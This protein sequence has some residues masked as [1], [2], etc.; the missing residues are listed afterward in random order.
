MIVQIK[1]NVKYPITL[2]PSVWIF[3]DRKIL[4]DNAFSQP[5]TEDIEL[6]EVELTG[7]RIKPPVNKSIRKY[8]KKELLSNSYAM[9]IHDFLLNAEI[10]NDA[11]E[12]ILET[13]QG[14]E[15]ISIKQLMDS[16]LLFSINGKQIKEQGPV[17]FYF[18]DGSN[19]DNPIKGIK[20]IHI[21]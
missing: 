7:N 17:H 2:D 11:T 14:Q 5:A 9:P 21:K 20:K 3:D 8:N 4:F 15:N 19:Q 13:D 1:G 6:D 18:G 10:D 12:V 16:L